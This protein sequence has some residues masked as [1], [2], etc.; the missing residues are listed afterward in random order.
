M[1][2]YPS[3][4]DV[5][6]IPG[7]QES[8]SPQ[9]SPIATGCCAVG[10]K[11]QHAN[12]N[13]KPNREEKTE[14]GWVDGKADSPQTPGEPTGTAETQVTATDKID[15]GAN[16]PIEGSSTSNAHPLPGALGEEQGE[17]VVNNQASEVRDEASAPPSKY[18]AFMP[19][20]GEYVPVT[21]AAPTEQG[22]IDFEAEK[23]AIEAL[24]FVGESFGRGNHGALRN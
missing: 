20:H 9:A 19:V 11:G 15:N 6:A 16:R 18:R 23:Q 10:V 8:L 7:S 17:P 3:R 2:C 24:L 21:S 22:D 14:N 1:G 12:N 5:V 4:T 13:A